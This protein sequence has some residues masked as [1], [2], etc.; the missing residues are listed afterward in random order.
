MHVPWERG[1]SVGRRQVYAK[2]QHRIKTK[3][4]ECTLDGAE[5]AMSCN[6]AAAAVE[7]QSCIVALVHAACVNGART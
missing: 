4:C 5:H 1:R 3:R 7:T 2:H 6:A